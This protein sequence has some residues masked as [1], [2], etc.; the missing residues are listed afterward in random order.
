M[1]VPSIT[2]TWRYAARGAKSSSGSPGRQRDERRADRPRARPGSAA[3]GAAED[4]VRRPTRARSRATL[5]TIACHVVEV[6]DAGI[7]EPDVR[8][9][10]VEDDEQR[11][12]REP[13]RVR[14]PLEPVQRLGHLGRARAGTSASGRARRRGL[15]RTRRRRRRRRPRDA[16]ASAARGR[17]ARS[18]TTRRSM[19]S[20][21]SRGASGGGRR[22]RLSGTDPTIPRD[23]DELAAAGVELL[24][25]CAADSLAEHLEDLRLRR[26]FTKT[27]KRKPNLASYSAF[28]AASS[29]ST[30]G[31]SIAALLRGRARREPASLTDRRVRCQRLDLVLVAQSREDVV[32]P[33]ERIV[34]L[35]QS[36]RRG[37][38]VP[39][40]ARA[41]SSTV[42]FRGRS[43]TRTGRREA[44]RGGGPSAEL[45]LAPRRG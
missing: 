26:R 36:A 28:S 45:D 5:S 4:V 25:A 42:S 35:G 23:R 27:T 30:H 7:D 16:S 37:A 1:I 8:V 41:S 39:R 22:G 38:C 14:L 18:R 9:E 11:E 24:L 21:R 3:D 29:T 40:R 31:S 12:A 15:P 33:L 10:V 34:D 44:G 19:R 17:G 13:R 20:R 2:P 43:R 6:G 32:R